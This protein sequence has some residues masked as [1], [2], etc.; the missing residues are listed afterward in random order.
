M[1]TLLVAD[2]EPAIRGLL[3]DFFE[4][5]GYA[6]VTAAD[7]HQALAH[8]RDAAPDLVLLDVMMPGPDGFEVVRQLRRDGQIPVILLTARVSETDRVVGLELGADDYVTK[9]F[10]LHEVAAR[11]KAVLRRTRAS[12]PPTVLR[13]GDVVLDPDRRRVTVRGAAVDLTPSEFTVLHTLMAAPG[14]VISREQL[15]DALGADDS[16]PRTVDVHVRN[17]R[18]KVEADASAPTHVETV[19]GVGY[20]FAEGAA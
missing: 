9:P 17:L 5:Q 11:V 1:T 16:V 6:V 10:S 13:G 18:V 19:F 3:R 15:L 12:A 20:R 4:A 7:G 2:D 14:R 8:A